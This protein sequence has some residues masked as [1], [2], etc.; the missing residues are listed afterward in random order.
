MH[1]V[2]DAYTAQSLKCRR[3]SNGGGPEW[4]D[5]AI[6]G[7]VG[8]LGSDTQISGV[9]PV[10]ILYTD[11]G[12]RRVGKIFFPGLSPE[13]VDGDEISATAIT[14]I[15]AKLESMRGSFN[16][17]GGTTPPVTLCIPRH[18]NLA[19]RSNIVGVSVSRIVG[20]QRRRQLPA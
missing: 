13:H 4:V 8:D 3:V 14:T 6:N 16:A 15:K 9:G 7:E 19:I 2:P 1:C 20:K 18:D 11:G 10:G 12:P 5:L 17:V